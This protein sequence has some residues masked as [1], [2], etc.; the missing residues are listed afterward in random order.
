MAAGALAVGGLAV[1][2]GAGAQGSG[3]GCLAGHWISNGLSSQIATGLGGIR[4]SIVSRGSSANGTA[5]YDF[6]EPDRRLRKPVHR[7]RPRFELRPI[8]LSG[9]RPLQLSAGP[10][11]KKESVFLGSRRV[12]GPSAVN[13]NGQAHY[14][15]LRC[16][17]SRLT[18]VTAVP[19]K[20]GDINV[21]SSF[22]RA[23]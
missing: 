6:L 10:Q 18:D 14:T 22:R 13:A 3:L 12:S 9:R 19:T 2:A 15:D 20:A 11:L 1:P 7:L 21:A 5:D 16:T 17:G 8:P 4:L 23:G